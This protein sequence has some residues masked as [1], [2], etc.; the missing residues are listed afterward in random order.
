MPKAQAEENKTD[1]TNVSIENEALQE[2]N[3]ARLKKMQVLLCSS[4]FLLDIVVPRPCRF[5][6]FTDSSIVVRAEGKGTGSKN[7]GALA[8]DTPASQI[9][10]LARPPSRHQVR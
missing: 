10:G 6:H 5:L 1:S 3:L 2:I 8:E 9:C 7:G 4:E